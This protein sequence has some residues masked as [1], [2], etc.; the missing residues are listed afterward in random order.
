M[1][2]LAWYL[3]LLALSLSAA[4]LR[5]H[6]GMT[7][8]RARRT[9][10]PAAVQATPPPV[11]ASASWR[12]TSEW[13]AP[14]HHEQLTAGPAVSVAAMIVVVDLSA[15]LPVAGFGEPAVELAP[16]RD[17]EIDLL[18]DWEA[19]WRNVGRRQPV[20]P[21][22]AS[23]GD[24]PT[25]LYAFVPGANEFPAMMAGAAHDYSWIA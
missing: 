22:L 19:L 18:Q 10:R 2:L 23:S 4:L 12:T 21:E 14:F 16:E 9:A 6:L 25:D 11:R 1:L 8:A 5:Q 13:T 3:G 17:P 20:Q 15:V 24:L 7:A